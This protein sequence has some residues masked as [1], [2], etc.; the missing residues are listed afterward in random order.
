MLCGFN[1]FYS[2][3]HFYIKTTCY[4]STE[5]PNGWRSYLFGWWN[6]QQILLQAAGCCEISEHNSPPQQK[7]NQQ[8]PTGPKIQQYERSPWVSQRRW[9]W[10][11]AADYLPSEISAQRE[12]SLGGDIY[13]CDTAGNKTPMRHSLLWLLQQ[14]DAHFSTP[15]HFRESHFKGD[16]QH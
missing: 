7:I 10:N 11:I 16:P 15:S 3:R 5:S 14:H 8:L 12:L 4:I 6:N 9:T 13:L 1:S 2:F